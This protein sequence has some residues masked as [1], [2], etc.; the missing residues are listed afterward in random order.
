MHSIYSPLTLDRFFFL[1]M[2]FFCHRLVSFTYVIQLGALWRWPY[3]TCGYVYVYYIDVCRVWFHR[4]VSAA[5]TRVYY[6]FTLRMAAGRQKM[7]SPQIA[8]HKAWHGMW[9]GYGQRR[10][11]R[12]TSQ[13]Q[14]C[15]Q[16]MHH[17]AHK[18]MIHLLHF[19]FFIIILSFA[20][21]GTK[22]WEYLN[23]Y[24]VWIRIFYESN[25]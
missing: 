7:C 12:E 1:S 2:F 25:Y 5:N 6:E 21:V 16:K 22:N 20:I 11:W 4:T 8:E 15:F 10:E 3:K 24:D 19:F 18:F 14:K 13:K 23:V 9:Y 17:C